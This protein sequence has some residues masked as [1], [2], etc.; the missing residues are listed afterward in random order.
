MRP[1]AFDFGV[2]AGIIATVVAFGIALWGKRQ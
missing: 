1:D 2:L